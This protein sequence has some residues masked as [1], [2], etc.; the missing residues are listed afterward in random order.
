MVM[1]FSSRRR[2][3]VEG[4]PSS[5]YWM[6]Y[7]DLMANLL[8]V[9]ALI[10]CVSMLMAARERREFITKVERQERQLGEKTD[11]LGRVARS[12]AE[13]LGIR[14]KIIEQLRD[15]LAQYD[16]KVD[17]DTGAIL[18]AAAVLFEQNQATVTA[19]GAE[20]LRL[21]MDAYTSVLLGDDKF[22][23]H[24][25]RIII[26]GHTNDDGGY[27]YNLDLSQRRAFS[28]MTNILAKYAD[29]PYAESL[30][31]FM[32]ASGRSLV[33]LIR[34]DT[35][36]VDK[37]RSRRIEIK[38]SLKDEDTIKELAHILEGKR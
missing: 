20:V 32:V 13:R 34:L 22:R 33:D 9:F 17:Q 21:V 37:V 27:V 7:S 36:D 29:S 31:R 38:F 25:S 24:L 5:D 3:D 4:D 11:E 14:R 19:E 1:T 26:E 6:T 23:T 35:G 30:Q 15:R 2:H 18:I 8:M 10:I 28:V 16:V 12:A